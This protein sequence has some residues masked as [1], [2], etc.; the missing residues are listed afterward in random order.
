M[1]FS[2]EYYSD[3]VQELILGFPDTKTPPMEVELARKRL[4]E[5]KR[6]HS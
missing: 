5:V 1:E 2:I 6:G 4:K 3:E